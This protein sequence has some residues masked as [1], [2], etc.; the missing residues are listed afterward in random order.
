MCST[1][2][3]SGSGFITIPGP[4]PYGTSSTLR[5][6]SVV[7][8]RRSCTFTSSNPRSMPR[9]TTPSA[10]PASTIRGKIVTMSNFIDLVRVVRIAR[11]APAIHLEQSLRRRDPNPLPLDVDLDANLGGQ[12]NQ[13]LAARPLDHQQAARRAAIHPHHVPDALA[14]HGLHRAADQLVVVVRARLERLQRLFR[15][16]QLQSGE[17]FDVLDRREPFEAD[18]RPAVLHARRRRPSAARRPAPTASR[19]SRRP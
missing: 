18:H 6:R 4:P 10:R 3:T 9:P 15:H 19:T 1:A 7:N 5:C 17:P 13:H 12:R 2:R 8:S 14:G 16:S 11:R